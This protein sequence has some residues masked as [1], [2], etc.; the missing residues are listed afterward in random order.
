MPLS[1]LALGSIM[2]D[3][4]L[5]EIISANLLFADGSVSYDFSFSRV[6]TRFD[7]LDFNWFDT[8]AA[9]LFWL[10]WPYSDRALLDFLRIVNRDP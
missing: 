10:S 5:T 1:P 6:L 3:F 2:K 7:I 4:E 8:F 9:L